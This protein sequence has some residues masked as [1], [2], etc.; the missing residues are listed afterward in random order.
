MK[1]YSIFLLFILCFNS[2]LFA[3]LLKVSPQKGESVYT[4]LTR[5]NLTYEKNID[6]FLKQ[7]QNKISEQKGLYLGKEY[8]LPI[9]IVKFNNKNIRSTLNIDYETAKK[10]QEYNSIVVKKG[11]KKSSYKDDQILWVPFIEYELNNDINKKE[12]E[13]NVAKDIFLRNNFKKNNDLFGEKYKINSVL[14]NKLAGHY[15]YLI[16]GHGGPDPGAIG[17][18]NG[19]ELHEHQYAYDISLRLAKKLMESGAEVFLIVQDD[20]D[21]ISD[22]KFLKKSGTEKLV[23]GDTISS[24]QSIRLKQ[25]TDLVNEIFRTYNK[26]KTNHLLIEIHVDSRITDK[27]I[28]I[29]FYHQPES[30]KG[31]E[32]CE[33]LLNTIKEKYDKNQ[34]GR[35]YQGRIFGRNLWTLRN[36]IPTGVYV[37]LGNI[38]NPQDQI[39]LIE[40]SNR[41][42]IANW[43]YKGILQAYNIK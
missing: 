2:S 33:A 3:E 14:D 5:Y 40:P 32:F 26:K 9:K 28:D 25:R 34:P 38:Q 27:R 23:N 22:E 41:Q 7:N 42:A 11:L 1:N 19:F 43:L 20:E 13:K 24:V 10:I 17:F 21:E 39:R 35:G 18:R 6:F 15:F 36:A 8:E 16:S 12:N 29:F 37:E 31:K 30:E 4:L